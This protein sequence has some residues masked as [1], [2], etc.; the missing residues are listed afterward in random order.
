MAETSILRLK[1]DASG[2]V[3]G[4]SEFDRAAKRSEVTAR[5]YGTALN[6]QSSA[7][8]GFGNSWL[9]MAGAV[10]GATALMSG[11]LKRILRET[12][13]AEAVQARLAVAITATAGAAGR[14]ITQL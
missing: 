8:R 5:S 13:E 6:T 1:V 12:M 14:S 7:I 3:T 4:F 10:L 11:V 9:V 2:A